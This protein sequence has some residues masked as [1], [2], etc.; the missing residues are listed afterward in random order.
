MV[1]GL[2]FSEIVLSRTYLLEGV[3]FSVPLLLILGSHEMGHYL[4]CRKLGLAATLPYFIPLPAGIGTLGAVIRI[5]E[6]VRTKAQLLEVGVAGPIAGFIALLP[7]L[8]YGIAQA[9]VVEA[10]STV[11]GPV[12]YFGEPLIF[13][14]AMLLFGPDLTNGYTLDLPPYAWAAWFGLL[15]TLLNLLPLAQLDGGHISYALAGPLHRKSVW[16]LLLLLVAL[17]FLWS[18]WW[19][20]VAIALLLGVEH[21]RVGDE[22]SP[23]TRRQV[24]LGCIALAIFVLCFMPAPIQVME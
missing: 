9:T 20:W 19:L 14:A 6:P 4:A 18:G 7:F 1:K 15:I 5:K 2:S 10:P 24:V 8:F 23:L 3:L 17:G 16:W 13:R 21:P 12:W 22:Q 11:T